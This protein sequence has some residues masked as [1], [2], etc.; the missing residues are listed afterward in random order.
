MNKV[1]KGEYGYLKYYKLSKLLVV[2]ILSIML[3][4]V[5]IGTIIMFGD[6]SRVI[7]V[8]AIL[9]SLPLAK[10]L[11]A[12]IIVAK[13]NSLSFDK[14]AKISNNY[15]AKD[16]CLMFDIT[17]SQYEGIKF[18]HSMLIKNGKIYALVLNKDYSDKKKDYEKWIND[19]ITSQKYKYKITTFD[20]IEEYIKK[21][22]SVSEPNDNNKLIDRHIR[23]EILSAGV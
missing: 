22:N 20:N 18:Y 9:L 12:Y 15:K 16:S 13:Y 5:V 11:I 23:E 7:I 14:H 3:A 8:I 4:A 10:F 2:G 19:S 1:N 6:T 21:I 17:I